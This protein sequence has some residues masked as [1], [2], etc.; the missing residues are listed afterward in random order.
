MPYRLEPNPFTIDFKFE[1]IYNIYKMLVTP[2]A[3]LS[4]QM[5]G[6]AGIRPQPAIAQHLEKAHPQASTLPDSLT[7]SSL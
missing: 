4:L 5:Q 6:G 3:G 2:S 1:T 7:I